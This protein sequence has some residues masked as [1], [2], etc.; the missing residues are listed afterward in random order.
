MVE[1]FEIRLTK[2]QADYIGV[3]QQGPFKIDAYKY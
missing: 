2:T 3:A 1:G